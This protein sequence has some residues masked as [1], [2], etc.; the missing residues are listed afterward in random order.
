MGNHRVAKAGGN[1]ASYFC[2]PD[3]RVIHAVLGQVPASVFLREAQWAVET[4]RTAR[5]KADGDE[6]KFAS[7]LA[8]AHK[9][10]K[11]TALQV[12]RFVT[13]NGSV[14]RTLR[15]AAVQRI[16][17]AKHAVVTYQLTCEQDTAKEARK[18]PAACGSCG[19]I[20]PEKKK[21]SPT[22]VVRGLSTTGIVQAV[23]AQR[24]A[25]RNLTALV[26][27]GGRG[28]LGLVH[29]TLGARPLPPLDDVYARFFNSLGERIS[30]E[31]VRERN[32][33][34]HRKNVYTLVAARAKRMTAPPKE[35]KNP[36]TT[37]TW[38]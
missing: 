29:Q 11:Q 26:V 13:V 5:K 38:Y 3:G 9:S 18:A 19:Q 6:E 12:S 8:E 23:P 25:A 14:N 16:V 7:L 22:R 10:R 36:Q 1:V 30:D 31:E 20:V 24:L 4:Y 37:Q 35:E 27:L 33:D 15:A 2:T 21:D 34:M 28:R 17:L 32:I